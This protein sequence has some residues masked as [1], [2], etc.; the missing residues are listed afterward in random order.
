MLCRVGGLWQLLTSPLRP[1]LSSR[2][3]PFS[4]LPSFLHS[5]PVRYLGDRSGTSGGRI[6]GRCMGKE[7][8][9]ELEHARIGSPL[10]EHLTARP[11]AVISV[12]RRPRGGRRGGPMGLSMPRMGQGERGRHDQSRSQTPPVQLFHAPGGC[13]PKHGFFV[14]PETVSPFPRVPSSVGRQ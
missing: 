1:L 10:H 5:L 14:D 9:R 6:G 13:S 7:R 8:R 11:V 4:F 3:V 12:P 2:F